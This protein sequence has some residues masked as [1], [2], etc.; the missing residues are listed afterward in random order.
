MNILPKWDC[1]D[2]QKSYLFVPFLQ[3]CVQ[4]KIDLDAY[5]TIFT[6]QKKPN[7]FKLSDHVTED[8]ILA[9]KNWSINPVDWKLFCKNRLIDP[10]KFLISIFDGEILKAST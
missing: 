5:F 2:I 7:L 6:E 8:E 10:Q 9:T 4:N 3:I 1:K